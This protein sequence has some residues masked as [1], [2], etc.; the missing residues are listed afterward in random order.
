MKEGLTNATNC[1]KLGAMRRPDYRHDL[2]KARFDSLRTLHVSAACKQMG[3]SR[4]HFY[5]IVN[6]NPERKYSVAMV[7]A[8]A[9]VLG[10]NPEDILQPMP[11]AEVE[12]DAVGEYRAA[13][14]E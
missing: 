3:M 13:V 12:A 6:G 14:E 5:N 11:K 2:L 1:L 9:C 10:L 7:R 4:E 8:V